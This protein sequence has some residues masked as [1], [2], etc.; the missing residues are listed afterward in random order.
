MK[1]SV[2][3]VDKFESIPKEKAKK[4]LSLKGTEMVFFGEDFITVK[5]EQN[6]VLKP[7]FLFLKGAFF[8]FHK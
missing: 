3:I 7:S 8:Y 2:V 4:I 5:K 1:I 6:L